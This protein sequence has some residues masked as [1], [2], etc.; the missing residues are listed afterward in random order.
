MVKAFDIKPYKNFELEKKYITRWGMDQPLSIPVVF[1][2]GINNP[3]RA[4]QCAAIRGLIEARRGA[5]HLTIVHWL[6]SLHEWGTKVK[7][8][9]PMVIR[10]TN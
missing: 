8:D 2:P 9:M 5:K 10:W 3:L 1:I 4:D 7:I 6:A